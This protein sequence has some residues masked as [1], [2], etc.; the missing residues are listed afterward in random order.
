M[1]SS[2]T[3][4]VYVDAAGWIAFVNRRDALH[5]QAVRIYRQLLQEQCQ[6][7]TVVISVIS[8][9]LS[10]V[11]PI[12]GIVLT[13]LVVMFF[14]FRSETQLGLRRIT[15]T[16]LEAALK[17]AT[18]YLGVAAIDVREWSEPS[19]QVFLATILKRKIENPEFV[20]NRILVFSKSGF[21]DLD[22]QYLDGYFAK[23]LI[24]QHKALDIGLAYL[25]PEELTEVM[26][27]FTIEEAKA[28]G[29]YPGWMPDWLLK[30]TPRSWHTIWHRRLALSVVQ[31]GN[32]DR[33]MPFSK[34]GIN[35]DVGEI[36]D[37]TT[38]A[39][40]INT[41]QKLVAEIRSRAFKEGVLDADHDFTKYY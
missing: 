29:Y 37:K 14:V 35:I 10:F 41:Y 7:M 9:S 33:F 34:N 32:N 18:G 4:L 22:S 12:L 6:F 2:S 38:D 17:E 24:E 27:K 19:P 16:K 3:N 28:I 23:A 21:K 39:D 5:T 8:T 26:R 13:Y 15:S 25:R 20:Y 31:Y 40:R 30:A 36:K 1:N 11:A